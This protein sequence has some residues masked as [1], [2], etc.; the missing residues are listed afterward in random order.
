MKH[1]LRKLQNQPEHIRKIILWS[2]IV[3][4]GLILLSWWVKNTQNELRSFENK[5]LIESLELPE[6]EMLKLEIPKEI[7]EE[8]NKL[9]ETLE[10]PE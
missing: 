4:L 5:G 10:E 2:V 1:I 6:I 9:K 8:L 7:N 3:I